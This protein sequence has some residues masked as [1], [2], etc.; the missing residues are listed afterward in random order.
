LIALGVLIQA[1]TFRNSA[2]AL[3]T[4]STSRPGLGLAA[5]NR[6]ILDWV[7]LAL[8]DQPERRGLGRGKGSVTFWNHTRGVC[9]VNPP[10]NQELAETAP[11]WAEAVAP[12]AEAVAQLL[13]SSEGSRIREV[14]TPLTGRNRSAR[15]GARRLDTLLLERARRR[16]ERD[17]LFA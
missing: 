12:A 8:L 13:A 11:R 10:L 15:Y 14:S 6:L 7:D 9:R 4:C 3:K 1:L 5:T 16:N 2:T 17:P